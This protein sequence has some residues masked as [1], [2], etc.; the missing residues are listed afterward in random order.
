MNIE[1]ACHQS[2]G[3]KL[4][5]DKLGGVIKPDEDKSGGD[6]PG[7]GKLGGDT[8]GGDKLDGE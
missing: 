8:P 5:S 4:G 1:Q 6:N 7:A 2:G 3:D